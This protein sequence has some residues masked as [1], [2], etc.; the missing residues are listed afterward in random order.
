MPGGHGQPTAEHSAP[1]NPLSQSP[2]PPLSRDCRFN[3]IAEIG[4]DH[5]PKPCAQPVV[6][7]YQ[8]PLKLAGKDS[9][10]PIARIKVH[11]PRLPHRIAQ[12]RHEFS[13]LRP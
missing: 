10:A 1:G 6:F 2:I 11:F 9:F 12:Q 4:C 5:G 7:T 8:V 3:L 13:G